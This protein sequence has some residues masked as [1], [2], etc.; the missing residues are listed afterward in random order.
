MLGLCTEK[1]GEKKF[2]HPSEHALAMVELF[3]L[4]LH[5][6]SSH[7]QQKSRKIYSYYI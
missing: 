6:S 4:C 2:G 3:S 7:H 5:I 1:Q